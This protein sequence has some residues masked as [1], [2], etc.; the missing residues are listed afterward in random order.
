MSSGLMTPQQLRRHRGAGGSGSR[1]ARHEGLYFSHIRGEGETLF[2]ATAEAIEIG[3]RAGVPVQIA[4]HKAAFRPNWGR[5]PHVTRLANG[6]S[7]AGWTS[8]RRLPYTAG[9]AGLTQLIPDW[10][11]EGGREALL[12]RL[13]DAQSRARLREEVLAG[14]GA[15]LRHHRQQGGQPPPGGEDPG[16]DR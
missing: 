13:R 16:G 1:P 12:G 8:A 11:H 9:S 15:H 6:R 14:V 7:T 2:R 3:E 10:A 5:M 4:H